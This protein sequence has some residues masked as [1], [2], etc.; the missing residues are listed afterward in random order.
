MGRLPGHAQA[1]KNSLSTH[2]PQGDTPMEPALKGATAFCAAFK[3]DANAN[4]DGED[5]A[6][7]LISDG[8]PTICSNEDDAIARADIAAVAADAFDN[9]P[10]VMTF[11]IGMLGADFGLLHSIAD[12]G[13]S[14]CTP[15]NPTPEACDLT[16][17]MTLIQALEVIRDSITTIEIHTEVQTEVL[18]CEWEIPPPP[19]GE[20]F[21]RDLV[22][23][24]FSPTASDTDTVIIGRVDTSES[25]SNG[26]GW[27]YDN[28]SD[29]T[30]IIACPETCTAI[31][32]AERAKVDILFGCQTI[33]I[34]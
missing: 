31:Q 11:A 32:T 10:N 14:D 29:P 30:R 24:Q 28:P 16:A 34:E 26:P 22:N 17:G 25:C 33:I 8:E 23:V 15:A 20:R 3:E 27:Y 6:V 2:V 9:A 21:D 4:P 12:N 18:E 19:E 13:G 5:C 7:V 1:I